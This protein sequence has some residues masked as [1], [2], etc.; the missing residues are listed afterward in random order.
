MMSSPD[1]RRHTA[2]EILALFEA[3]EVPVSPVNSI[4][5]V[6]EHPHV[7]ARENFVAV[8]DSVLGDVWQAAP[9]PRFSHRPGGI[10][11]AGEGLGAST[12][13][14]LKELGITVPHPSTSEGATP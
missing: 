14:V 6:M 4:A 5:D 10:R 7:R 13:A 2:E 1:G 11:W 12:D 3:A 8:P 9:V